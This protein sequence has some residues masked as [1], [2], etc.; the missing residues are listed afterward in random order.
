MVAVMIGIDPHKRSNTAVV[1]DRSE[2]VLARRR[3]TNDGAGY[4]ELKVFVKAWKQRTWAVE[5]ARGVG[6]SLAQ[7][8]A[9]EGEHVL[10]VPAFLSARVRAL[11]GGSGRKTDDSDAYAVAVAGLRGHDL[12]I[13][14]PEDAV[15]VLKMLSD[16]RQQLVEQ[17]IAAINRLHDVLQDLL[18]GGAST[19]LTASKAEEILAA[20]EP[21]GAVEQTRKDIALDHAQDVAALDAKV[22]VVAKQIELAVAQQPSRVNEIRG[23][24]AIGTALILGE[25]GDVRRFRSKHHF[26]SY[27]GTAPIDVS[28]GDQDRHRLNRGGNRRLN[29]ALHV[30]ALVQIRYPSPGQTY[31]L[32]KRAEGKKPLEAMRCLK[33]RLSDV[34]FHAL[35]Q[36]LQ[37]R[38]QAAG[39]AGHSGATLDSSA[40]DPTRVCCNSG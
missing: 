25:V 36:D 7:R 5:G 39:P 24:G 11:G 20:I 38:L 12:Q 19:R 27:T 8:L 32:R 30:A 1:L 16:R 28:S 40:S 35:Q 33:R 9:M 10:D 22:K 17:R 3:F 31:Y 15:A 2:K 4:R 34:V 6:L 23:I 13:V 26:A 14:R 18:P 21:V 37:L 29:Y